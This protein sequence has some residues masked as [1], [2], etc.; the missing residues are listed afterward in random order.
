MDTWEAFFREKSKRRW[1]QHS[2][3]TAVKRGILLLLMGGVAAAIVM[4]VAG[5]PR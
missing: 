1:T 5:V 2:R 4:L 3:E